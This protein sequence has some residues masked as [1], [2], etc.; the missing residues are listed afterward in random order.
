MRGFIAGRPVDSVHPGRLERMKGLGTAEMFHSSSS[1][2]PAFARSTAHQQNMEV[3]RNRRGR[4]PHRYG[5]TSRS[6]AGGGGARIDWLC[7]RWALQNQRLL[8]LQQKMLDTGV[9]CLVY[10]GLLNRRRPVH[11]RLNPKADFGNATVTGLQ[12]PCQQCSVLP[13]V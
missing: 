7:G 12:T 8:V 3:L 1:R 11:S 13:A 10:L 2:K 6:G 4:Q 9:F 5:N